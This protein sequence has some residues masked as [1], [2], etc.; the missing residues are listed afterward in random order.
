MDGFRISPAQRHRLEV[1]CRRFDEVIK[2][3]CFF[4]DKL[5]GLVKSTVT[6]T[7]EAAK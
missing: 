6:L 7:L 3:I 2:T 1:E 5:V 4:S